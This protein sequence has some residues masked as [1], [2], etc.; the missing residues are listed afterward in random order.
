MGIVWWVVGWIVGVQAAMAGLFAF[1]GI[2][3]PGLFGL[4]AHVVLFTWAFFVM[5]VLGPLGTLQ[6]SYRLDVE[7][8]TITISR[9]FGVSR[10]TRSVDDV[11]TVEVRSR[12]RRQ[13][14][15]TR[16]ADGLVLT[17]DSY[18]SGFTQWWS[19]L[20]QHRKAAFAKAA[21]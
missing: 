5:F 13:R 20:E 2:V 17:T 1:P 7:N 14:L 19:Y 12:K 6:Y 9:Y 3:L 10:A 15:R 8:R 18:A 11:V 16:F 4:I 21:T